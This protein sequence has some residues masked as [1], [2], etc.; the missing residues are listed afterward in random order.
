MVQMAQALKQKERKITEF[1]ELKNSMRIEDQLKNPKTQEAIHE[2]QC[3]FEQ[4]MCS[5]NP[6]S[7]WDKNQHVVELPYKEIYDGK[8]C[9]RRAIPMNREY[10]K[11][12]EEEVQGLLKKGLIRHLT[13][14]WNCYGFYVN[15]HSEKIIGVPRLVINYKPLNKV[16]VDDTYPIPHK[17]SLV[18]RIVGA[19][20]FSKF[21][22][23]SG[24]WQ[25]AVKE[26]DKFKIAFSVPA[27]T[28]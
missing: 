9:K 10:H 1:K 7:F 25:V 6:T 26:E 17:S 14:P 5:E 3:Q 11:L 28:L 19:Q 12:C 20:I 13:S 23:K 27:R 24:F 15:K 4:I 21:D 22:L 16:L 18:N 8:P 2:L